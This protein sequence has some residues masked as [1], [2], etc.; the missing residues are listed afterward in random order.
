MGAII[1]SIA[2]NLIEVAVFVLV[3]WAGIM[4]GKSKAMKKAADTKD[5]K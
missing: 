4:V 3:A 2:K 5:A 1:G